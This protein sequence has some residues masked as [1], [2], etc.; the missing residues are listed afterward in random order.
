MLHT[1]DQLINSRQCMGQERERKAGTVMSPDLLLG[2]VDVGGIYRHSDCSAVF[3][4][5]KSGVSLL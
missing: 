4:S 5:V 1:P 3:Q 2:K